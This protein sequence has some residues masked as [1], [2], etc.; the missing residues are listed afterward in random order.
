MSIKVGISNCSLRNIGQAAAGVQCIVLVSTLQE[1]C[2]DI[3]KSAEKID[4]DVAGNGGL[5]L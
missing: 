4:Q 2:D 3:R 5:P 1:G